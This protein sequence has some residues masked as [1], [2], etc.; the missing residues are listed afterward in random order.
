MVRY[1]LLGVVVAALAATAAT[2]QIAIREQDSARRPP[3]LQSLEQ[4]MTRGDA[5]R[6]VAQS[7]TQIDLTLAGSSKIIS[8]RQAQLI[9]ERF[10]ES[11]P[12]RKF[13]FTRV[14]SVGSSWFAVG[15]YYEED[16]EV[17]YEVYLYLRRT[18]RQWELGEIKVAGSKS[19]SDR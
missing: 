13:S 16:S 8:S 15:S 1:A 12:P 10:F 7:S 19:G 2:G 3:L 11:H 18:D 14:G 6:L 17:P 9:L 4:A 5:Q